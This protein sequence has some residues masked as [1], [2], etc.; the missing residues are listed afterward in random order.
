M[1]GDKPLGPHSCL[2]RNPT[3]KTAETCVACEAETFFLQSLLI[4][5][6]LINSTDSVK[7]LQGKCLV[8]DLFLE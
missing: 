8:H 2:L 6:P 7:L 5:A 1:S 3:L 4:D